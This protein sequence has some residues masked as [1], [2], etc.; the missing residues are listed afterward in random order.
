MELKPYLRQAGAK[1]RAVMKIIGA[2]RDYLAQMRSRQAESRQQVKT[3][4]FAGIIGNFILAIFLVLIFIRNITGRLAILV[5]N[6]RLLPAGQKLKKHVMGGDELAYLDNALHSAAEELEKA[7]A[8]RQ[9]LME[10]VAHDLRSP[11][12]SSQVA[13]EIL[14]D[15]KVANAL[16]PQAVRQVNAV[17]RNIGRLVTLTNDLLTLDKLEAG[18][19]EPELAFEDIKTTVEEALQS[20]QALARQKGIVLTN[21]CQAERVSIDRARILQVLVN[22]LSN[23]IKFSPVNG[24][25]I[26]FTGRDQGRLTVSVLDQGPGL[27]AEVQARL[28]DKYYQG[29]GQQSK[30]YGLGLAIAKLIVESHGGEVGVDSHPGHGSRFWF[31]LRADEG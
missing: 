26:V 13:L 12:M 19:L 11:L 20:V 28:F 6:A 23:A 9:S 15:E 16:P 3:F 1:S 14:A 27:T 18:K 29:E 2:Q 10:M 17:Q 5:E 31:S 21:N 24:Q 7:A 8:Q 4:V 22:Y 30:G 25:I